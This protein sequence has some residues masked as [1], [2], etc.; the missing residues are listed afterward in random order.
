DPKPSIPAGDNTNEKPKTVV[1]RRMT[2]EEQEAKMQVQI[3]LAERARSGTTTTIPTSELLKMI[4]PAFRVE[5]RKQLLPQQGIR[6]LITKSE[7]HTK[8]TLLSLCK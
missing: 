6:I 8:T 4:Y 7:V 1:R 5:H 2:K 3:L